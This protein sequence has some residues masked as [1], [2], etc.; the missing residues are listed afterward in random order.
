MN[1]EYIDSNNVIERYLL[2]RLDEAEA[3]AFEDTF[4]FDED[5][6]NEINKTELLIFSLRAKEK[7]D[8]K[9]IN[10]QNHGDKD[11]HSQGKN[12]QSDSTHE[13]DIS[14]RD[15]PGSSVS[16]VFLPL[17]LAANVVLGIAVA[18][19]LIKDSGISGL[20]NLSTSAVNVPI[21]KLEYTRSSTNPIAKLNQTDDWV[22]LAISD[23]ARD[24]AV[25]S[26]RIL[27]HQ[28]NIV[29]EESQVAPDS[30]DPFN[31]WTD[32]LV[33]GSLLST[34]VWTLEVTSIKP[35]G[36][37][38]VESIRFVVCDQSSRSPAQCQS[39]LD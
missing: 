32:W 35:D 3:A 37:T 15:K 2:G 36:K 14:K 27:D 11:A 6:Q 5:L 22:I 7:A 10:P 21:V 24:G 33:H 23:S 17:S 25:R 39:H 28:G 16:R 29:V 19:N 31:A 20:E 1:R 8:S 30:V 13:T 26:L 34:G 18:N 4:T 12:D 9:I 38:S